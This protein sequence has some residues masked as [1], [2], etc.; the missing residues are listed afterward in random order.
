MFLSCGAKGVFGKGTFL[1]SA[2]CLLLACTLM[3]PGCYGSFPLTRIVH[4]FNGSV[5]HND[6]VHTIIFWVFL[7]I[8]VYHVAMIAD[9]LVPN[10]IEFWTG[11]Q[12][13][14]EVQVEADG[15]LLTI[16]PTTND[17]ML[18]R[19]D[20]PDAPDASLRFVRVSK[21]RID[22]FDQDGRKAGEVRR[23]MNG[24]ISLFDDRGEVV[25]LLDARQVAA[26]QMP[27]QRRAD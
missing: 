26:I 12:I 10:L 15:T 3:L 5:T 27:G 25:G 6:L 8:P 7:I 24:D 16:E 17:E 11:E 13:F 20:F 19:F 14:A 9:A 23:A 2:L 18:V 21:E 1:T 22:V 4:K